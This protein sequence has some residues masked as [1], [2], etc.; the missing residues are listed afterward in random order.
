MPVVA[1]NTVKKHTWMLESSTSLLLIGGSEENPFKFSRVFELHIVFNANIDYFF[2]S[3]HCYTLSS[4]T[5][6][7]VDA[8]HNDI[9][10][11]E[12]QVV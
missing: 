2:T 7:L 10:F 12:W 9:F 11:T 8:F 4:V 6:N 3:V 5:D 1:C